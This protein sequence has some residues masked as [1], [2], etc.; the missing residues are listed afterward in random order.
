MKNN[1]LTI[2]IQ[3]KEYTEW[4]ICHLIKTKSLSRVHNSQWFSPGTISLCLAF[5]RSRYALIAW[6][7]S[8]YFICVKNACVLKNR[9]DPEFTDL[10][11]QGSLIWPVFLSEAHIQRKGW[12]LWRCLDRLQYDCATCSCASLLF[13]GDLWLVRWDEKQTGNKQGTVHLL[14]ACPALLSI[15]S[16]CVTLSPSWNCTLKTLHDFHE[17]FLRTINGSFPLQK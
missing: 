13:V 11:F 5:S 6:S 8:W 4:E 9:K 7:F 12:H 1:T 17:T 16:T 14:Y 10:E 15:T 2:C 3:V